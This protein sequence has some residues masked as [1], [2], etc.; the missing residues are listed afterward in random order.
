MC[1]INN[2]KKKRNSIVL[3]ELCLLKTKKYVKKNANEFV[4]C[5]FFRLLLWIMW[6][7][8]LHSAS[9]YAVSKTITNKG[10]LWYVNIDRCLKILTR[11]PVGRVSSPKSFYVTLCDSIESDPLRTVRVNP[12]DS[13]HS[14]D[15]MLWEWV[16]LA[17]KLHSFYINLRRLKG[18]F[19]KGT[20]GV[21]KGRKLLKKT[22]RKRKQKNWLLYTSLKAYEEI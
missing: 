9:S 8:G 18:S 3:Y 6:S 21:L 17:Q 10:H 4:C 14:W 19:L 11:N 1:T 22:Y 13:S 7:I 16:A 5:V 20:F 2:I 15:V 12:L